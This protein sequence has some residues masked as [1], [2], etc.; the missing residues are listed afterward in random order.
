VES[1][2]RAAGAARR[3]PSH[4]WGWASSCACAGMP[5][6]VEAGR[7][8]RIDA[9][10]CDRAREELRCPRRHRPRRYGAVSPPP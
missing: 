1:G 8:S 7:T 5:A 6:P 9:G 3:R 10:L 4:C 2:A